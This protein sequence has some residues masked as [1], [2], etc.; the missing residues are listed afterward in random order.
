[1]ME[2]VQPCCPQS[3]QSTAAGLSWRPLLGARTRT[4]QTRRQ[5][6]WLVPGRL[7]TDRPSAQATAGRPGAGHARDTHLG[8]S[9]RTE[10]RCFPHSYRLTGTVLPS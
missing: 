1:M 10:H 7:D 4:V 9:G 6:P 3:H 8:A 5:R 2:G